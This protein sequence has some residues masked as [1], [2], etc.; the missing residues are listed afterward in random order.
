MVI[1]EGEKILFPEKDIHKNYHKKLYYS[2]RNPAT[3][4]CSSTGS[5]TG[6]KGWR[7]WCRST[8]VALWKNIRPEP[9]G[10]S[11]EGEHS[12][13]PV[14]NTASPGRSAASPSFFIPT[15]NHASNVF[16]PC[17]SALVFVI[18]TETGTGAARRTAQNS[19]A[20]FVVT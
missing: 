4:S 5:D 15:K 20:F 3:G 2:H 9:G 17:I 10:R 13:L 12:F 6:S 19:P 16:T 11:G 8:I 14:G 7:K 18:L 1:E